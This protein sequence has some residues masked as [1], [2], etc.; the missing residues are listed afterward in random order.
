[1]QRF[2]R[3]PTRS[4]IIRCALS[5]ATTAMMLPA[6]RGCHQCSMTECQWQWRQCRS[7]PPAKVTVTSDAQ[8][9]GRGGGS[10][11]CRLRL[12]ILALSTSTV[13]T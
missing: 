8:A 9:H 4:R 1:M 11:Q 12:G 6:S 3:P 10:C 5:G 7:G 13:Q 2:M